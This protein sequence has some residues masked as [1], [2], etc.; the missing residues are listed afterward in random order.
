ML[1]LWYKQNEF[2]NACLRGPPNTKLSLL[3]VARFCKVNFGDISAVE[4]WHLFSST[5]EGLF[6]EEAHLE[7]FSPNEY[8]ALLYT[9]SL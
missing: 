1:D 9:V 2:S 6:E 3:I 4:L 5:I 7:V 8:I